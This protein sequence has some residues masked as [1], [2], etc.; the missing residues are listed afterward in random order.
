[1]AASSVSN[2]GLTLNSFLNKCINSWTKKNHSPRLKGLTDPGWWTL[3]DK[4]ILCGILFHHLPHQRLQRT[5]LSCCETQT[6]LSFPT[7]YWPSKYSLSAWYEAGNSRTECGTKTH[8]HAL[9]SL[10]IS[11]EDR[12]SVGFPSGSSHSKQ[13]RPRSLAQMNSS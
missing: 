13:I 5:S 11:C 10:T 1:M 3:S 6:M 4:Q 12:S 7:S 8:N 2:G 9:P